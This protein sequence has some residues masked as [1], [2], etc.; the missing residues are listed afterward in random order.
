MTIDERIK[1]EKLQ[2]IINRDTGKM[3]ALSSCKIEK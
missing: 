3:S 1:N 2:Y